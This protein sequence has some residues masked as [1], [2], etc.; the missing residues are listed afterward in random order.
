MNKSLKDRAWKCVAVAF[1]FFALLLSCASAAATQPKQVVRVAFPQ[2]PGLSERLPDGSRRGVVYEWLVEIAKYTGW[3]YEFMDEKQV[4]DAVRNIYT[5]KYDLMGGMLKMRD[6]PSIGDVWFYPKYLMGFNDSVL[7]YN[8]DDQQIKNFDVSTLEQ[9]T[10]GVF[11]KAKNKIERLQ[12]V[13]AINNLHCKLVYYDDPAVYEL[14]L[15]NREVDLLL[16]SDAHVTDD[17]NIAIRF[18]SEPCYIVARKSNPEL[19]QELDEAIE[20]IYS[21]NPN[22]SEELYQKYFPERYK[23]STQFTR[24]ELQFIRQSAPLKVAVV[25]QDNYPFYYEIEDRPKG[26]VPEILQLLEQETGLQFQYVEAACYADAVE[27]VKTGKA[28]LLGDFINNNVVK[29]PENLLITKNYASLDAIVLRNKAADLFGENLSEAV[30][31]DAALSSS[32]GERNRILYFSS[33]GD[34]LEAVDTGKVDYT[35]IPMISLEYLYMRDYYTNVIPSVDSSKLYLSIAVHKGADTHLY[36]VLTKA[37][38]NLPT[39]QLEAVVTG[40]TLAAGMRK[41]SVKSLV[42]SNPVVSAVVIA[43]FFGL[44]GIILLMYLWFKLQNKI[45]YAKL[46][47]EKEISKV[48]SDFLSR[49]SHEIRTPLNAIIGFI[50]LMKLSKEGTFDV[51]KNLAKIDSAAQFLLS[52][53]NDILD[54]SKL[55]NNKMQLDQKP[56][57]MPRLLKQLEDIFTAMA[58]KKQLRLHFSCKISRQNFVGDEFR[59]QQILTNLLSNAYKFTNPGGEIFV[60][61]EEIRSDAAAAQLKFSVRDNGIGIHEEDRERIFSSFEQ[62]MWKN[63]A[64]HQGTGLGL[65]ISYHLVKLMDSVLQLESEIGKGSTFYFSVELP[66]YEG[67]L[68]EEAEEEAAEGAEGAQYRLLRGKRV[69]L[70]EDNELNAEIAMELLRLQGVGVEWATNGQEAVDRFAQAVEGGYDLILMDLQMPVKN[71]LEAA[72]EI[73]NLERADAKAVPILAMTANTLKED[74]DSA[75]AAGMNGFIPKPFDVEQLYRCVEKFFR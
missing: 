22:F 19:C 18:P 27:L 14:A 57:A 64:H 72:A 35:V 52:L 58:E 21:V 65:A 33:F 28:D 36:T 59:L 66:V 31:T 39:D 12:T 1:C 53:V 37:I 15:Q 9:K 70:V 67:A 45:A 43:S 61:V 3:E 24:E 54:M 38:V 68:A 8:R 63:R 74:R 11:S 75:F 30:M 60:T 25:A 48:R 71:G 49:M 47:Q 7:L 32:H 17:Y 13:L 62:V 6:I 55:E 16:A 40:N 73:R 29:Q 23:N 56:F 5:D 10:I 4:N 50:Q 34:C 26:I 2:A 51:Q 46:E 44:I 69:L 41:M 42:Y 20:K